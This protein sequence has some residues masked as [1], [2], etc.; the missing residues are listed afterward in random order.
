MNNIAIYGAGNIGRKIQ[1][2]L[3]KT[4]V[5]PLCFFDS[6][7]HGSISDRVHVYSIDEAPHE[8]MSQI[9]TIIVG[10]FNYRK[11][12]HL[13]N[14]MPYIL[15]FGKFK[16]I[17]FEEFYQNNSELF[18]ENFYWLAPIKHFESKKEDI[19]KA[20]ELFSDD[21]SIRIYDALISHRMGGNYSVLPEPYWDDTQYLPKD[22]PLCPQSYNFIDIGA[23]DGDT[24]SEF[25]KNGVKLNKIVAY[26]P[27]PR[28]FAALAERVK[29]EGPFAD[30]TY[31][32]PAGVGE[33]CGSFSFCSSGDMSS[34]FIDSGEEKIPIVSL[35]AALNGIKS[36]M[37]VK[38]DI[39]GAENPAILGMR[40]MIRDDKPILAVCVY[41]RPDDLYSIPLLLSEINPDQK[42][43]LRMHGAHCLET[44]LYAIPGRDSFENC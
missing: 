25:K 27:D 36:P 2:A 20:R 39:E 12:S 5:E 41:H 7:K 37:Y 31:L 23:F 32:I 10:V 18:G 40:N 15:K 1:A 21:K 29:N 38:M 24:L 4:G 35:D 30:E 14:L 26:E 6:V 16:V 34:G 22:V 3:K 8:I 33:T 42:F 13:T 19:K 44:V 11:E 28:N 9:N 43:Y 17:P